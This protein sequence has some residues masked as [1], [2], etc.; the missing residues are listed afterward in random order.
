MTDKQKLDLALKNT[1]N[2]EKRV[3][4]LELQLA[5]VLRSVRIL[6]EDAAKKK[7]PNFK[8]HEN[9]KA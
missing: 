2:L 3:E 1:K 5:L 4:E 8:T 6:T 7:D 9:V